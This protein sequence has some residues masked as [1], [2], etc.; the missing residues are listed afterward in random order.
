MSDEKT[1]RAGLTRRETLGLAGSAGAAL[2]LTGVARDLPGVSDDLALAHAARNCVRL[3]PEQEEGPFYVDLGRLRRNVVEGSEGV[4]LELRLLVV[5]PANCH[6]IEGAAVDIW[7]C[8][9]A[10][11]YSDESSNGTSGEEFLRGIQLTDQ[12]GLATFKTIYPGWYQGRATHIHLKV[13]V[14]GRRSGRHFNGGHVAHTGQMFFPEATS[15]VVYAGAPYNRET[16][17][18]TSNSSDHV[19]AQQ[20][21]AR[22]MLRLKGAAASG[23]KGMIAFGVDPKATPAGVGV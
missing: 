14:G 22:A 8:N 17:A 9:A 4:P 10:G 1:E 15:D 18:R 13:H 23:F 12:K 16:I 11:L 7:Q 19:Y 3:T 5:N 20:G 2:A 6:P 21:G